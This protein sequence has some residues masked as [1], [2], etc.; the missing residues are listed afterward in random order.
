MRTEC[1]L[2]ANSGHSPL[3]GT[4][5]NAAPIDAAAYVSVLATRPAITVILDLGPISYTRQR[6]SQERCR[7]MSALGHRRTFRSESPCPLYT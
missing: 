4:S 6:I 1:P 5:T 7:K 3:N 2:S